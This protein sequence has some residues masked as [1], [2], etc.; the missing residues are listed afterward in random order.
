MDISTSK[1]DLQMFR[2]D[3]LL[4]FIFPAALQ[5]PLAVGRLFAFALY[6]PLNS[7]NGKSPLIN[8]CP[9]QQVNLVNFLF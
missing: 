2:L 5:H 1:N 9:S 4:D 3:D 8:A 6:G 7:E